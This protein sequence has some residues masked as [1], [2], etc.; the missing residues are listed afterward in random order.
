VDE[1]QLRGHR[2]DVDGEDEDREERS[3]AQVSDAEAVHRG[4]IIEAPAPRNRLFTLC[5]AATG[6][7][8]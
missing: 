3:Q 8:A 7:S 1:A 2:H 4:M 5:F 6:A